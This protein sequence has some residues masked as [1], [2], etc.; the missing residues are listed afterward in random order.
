ME[1]GLHST[2][3]KVAVLLASALTVCLYL[4]L[5]TAEFI[6]AHLSTRTD[7]PNMQRAARLQPWDAEYEYHL[8]RYFLLLNQPADAANHLRRAIDLD[9]NSAHYW[10]D[11]AAAY[12]ALGLAQERGR[13]IEQAAAADPNNP[14]IAWEAANLY[15]TRGEKDRALQQFRVVLDSDSSLM[16]PALQQCLRITDVDTILQQVMPPI[17]HSYYTLLDLL[18]VSKRTAEAGKVWTQLAGLHQRLQ[19]EHVFAYADYL[20]GQREVHQAVAVWQQASTLANLTA[21]QPSRENLVVNG[22]FSLDVLNDGFDWRSQKVSG[23]TLARDPSQ[24]HSGHHSLAISFDGSGVADAGIWQMVPV[25][26]STAYDFSAYYKANGI[27][28]AG[29]PRFSIQDAYSDT[30]LFSSED[31]NNADFWKYVNGRVVTGPTT[32]LILIRIQRVPAGSPIRG[33]LWID[34]VHL[35]AM[36]NR[37]GE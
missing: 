10:F 8:G 20:L 18:M 1:S 22:D 24:S 23:V 26:P 30:L 12:N 21:Y 13:A 27:E 3:V 5:I 35:V 15:I 25:E 4:A 7:L 33:T 19:R 11:L 9:G 28:G 16:L 37:D 31:L 32:Q 2:K 36:E 17:P 34:G 29:G 6:A 14:E